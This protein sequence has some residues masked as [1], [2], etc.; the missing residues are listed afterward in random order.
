MWLLSLPDI[1][2]QILLSVWLTAPSSRSRTRYYEAYIRY[3]HD[4]IGPSN[5]IF[6]HG[7]G[8]DKRC[9]EIH[10]W[11]FVGFKAWM[12]MLPSVKSALIVFDATLQGQKAAMGSV[13][14]SVKRSRGTETAMTGEARGSTSAG[15]SFTKTTSCWHTN[16]TVR[17]DTEYMLTSNNMTN[18]SDALFFTFYD[19]KNT[20]FSHNSSLHKPISFTRFTE[21][22][23][24]GFP[25]A[26]AGLTVTMTMTS[27]R[28]AGL[29]AGLPGGGFYLRRKVTLHR[30]TLRFSS[31][32]VEG[33][34]SDNNQFESTTTLYVIRI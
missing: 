18:V 29:A 16:G 25:G 33:L 12:Y 5:I 20:C 17:I 1:L 23:T 7:I 8:I 22:L 31:L 6:W 27:S 19:N 11:G 34:R 2:L 28:S 15:R 3:V 32:F 14:P 21:T 24:S 26:T 9:W 10:L 4:V 13:P 30:S